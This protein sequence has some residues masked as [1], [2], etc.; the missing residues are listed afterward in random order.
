MVSVVTNVRVAQNSSWPAS[1]GPH[2]S[3]LEQSTLTWGFSISSASMQL[4]LT[5][6]QPSALLW[7]QPHSCVFTVCFSYER[8]GAGVH[9]PLTLPLRMQSGNQLVSISIPLLGNGRTGSCGQTHEE[10][11]WCD[12]SSRLDSSLRAEPD[13]LWLWWFLSSSLKFR[14]NT[15]WQTVIMQGLNLPPLY[16]S[17]IS[18][19]ILPLNSLGK[20]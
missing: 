1:T 14:T 12:W 9:D 4:Q 19:V 17:Y 18:K 13:H 15:L 3:G 16:F 7:R 6:Q 10:D 2:A 5:Q 20:L 8:G 11:K